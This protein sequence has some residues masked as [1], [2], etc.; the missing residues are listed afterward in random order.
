M[1]SSLN[2]PI[3]A[4][5]GMNRLIRRFAFSFD[6]RC[7]MLMEFGFHTNPR[8][9]EF[10]TNDANLQRLAVSQ[11]EILA[12]HFKPQERPATQPSA[13]APAPAT[14]PAG[15][16]FT[17]GD[18]VQFTG[19]GVFV[20]STAATPAHSRGP[21]RCR[22]SAT[23]PGRAQ[24]LHLISEDGGGVHGWVAAGDVSAIAAPSAP[25]AQPDVSGLTPITGQAIATAAQMRAY[26]TR[27]NPNAPDIADLF[28][29]EGAIEGIRGDIAFAQSCLE[30]GNFMFTGS[31]VT[32]AQNNFS[33][34]G[35]TQTGMTGN[36]FPTPQMGIRA[37][38][39][40]LK[41][42]ANTDPLVN[43]NQ[44]PRA[45]FVQRGSAPYVEWLGIQEN[46]NGRGWAAGAN[47]GE[48][49]LRILAAIIATNAPAGPSPPAT[50]QPTPEE[51]TVDAAIAAGI[52]TDRAHWLGVLTGN[53]QPRP[54]FIKI[55][56]DNAIGKLDP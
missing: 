6:P 51:I 2:A 35:V 11:A 5:L 36:S 38:I 3:S 25:A 4:P 21:S 34:M 50:P 54:A 53:V 39:H 52:I 46:P 18:I 13:P 26:I 28:I 33:G 16:P 19:G 22:V 14:P 9:A 20:S 1:S 8:D 29:S 30:T 31:A 27:I 43:E 55:M 7:A 40:H 41:A 56:M 24:P 15:G 23:A 17:V 47:Y 49:I 32:L 37:Q 44:S 12:D 45:Q 10:L 42:Y 48:K